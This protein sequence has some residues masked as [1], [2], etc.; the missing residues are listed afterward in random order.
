MVDRDPP[1]LLAVPLG[2]HNG[3]V[4]QVPFGGWNR[5]E[6][7]AKVGAALSPSDPARTAA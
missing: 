3:G 7:R 6:D 1:P 5:G 4:W 2:A